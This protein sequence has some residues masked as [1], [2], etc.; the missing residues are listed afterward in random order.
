MLLQRLCFFVMYDIQ[1]HYV[2]SSSQSEVKQN[3]QQLPSAKPTIIVSYFQLRYR[4]DTTTTL[5]PLSLPFSCPMV[6][7]V[8]GCTGPVRDHHLQ[9]R[10]RVGGPQVLRHRAGV[11]M[12]WINLHHCN[13]VEQANDRMRQSFI[14]HYHTCFDISETILEKVFIHSY[15]MVKLQVFY[16]VLHLWTRSTGTKL[17]KA[18]TYN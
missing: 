4:P 14:A 16:P 11:T 9:T 6:G 2:S 13:Q 18:K 10:V 3:W 5:I 7:W 8:G 12:P 1:L 17:F 15:T